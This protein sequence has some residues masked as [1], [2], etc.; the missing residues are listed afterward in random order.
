MSDRSSDAETDRLRA[1]LQAAHAALEDFS[2]AVSHDLRANLRHITYY[3][4]LL[5]EEA[6]TA[7]P[8]E[9]ASY[10]ETIN[11]AAR[12]LG[13]Q[14]DGLMTWTKLDRVDLQASVIDADALVREVR[15]Q[16]APEC[17]DRQI[18]WQVPEGLPVLRGD[19]ALLRQ[20]L[21]HLLSNALKFTR[22]RQMAVIQVGCQPAGCD[23][24]ATLFVRDNGVGFDSARQDK[25]CH[26]F[27]RLHSVSQFEGLGMGL[28]LSRKIVERHGGCISVEA[29]PDAG[30]RVSFSLPTA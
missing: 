2:Y 17:L 16:L 14:I 28:A 19:G 21:T 9:A 7:L 5:R 24:R 11:N 12:L 18:D 30:C 10:L 1:E 8:A 20:L 15:G 27:Q 3:A 23:G 29:S 22:P 25:L 26:V 4:A 6:G 13:G